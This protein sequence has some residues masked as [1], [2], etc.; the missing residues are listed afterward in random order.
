VLQ[1]LQQQVAAHRRDD[2]IGSARRAFKRGVAP[3][4]IASTLPAVML[5]LVQL[6]SRPLALPRP[7]EAPSSTVQPFCWPPVE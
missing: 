1:A 7:T 4:C 2:L 3:D 5:L 6:S